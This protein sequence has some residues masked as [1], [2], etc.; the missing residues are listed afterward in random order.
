MNNRPLIG[1]TIGDP[2]GV[3]PEIVAR[4]LA[5]DALHRQAR[6]VVI[7]SDPVVTAAVKLVGAP[8]SVHPIQSPAQG[9]FSTGTLDLID[10]ANVDFETLLPGVA[11]PPAGRAAF[12]YVERAIEMA[13]SGTIDAFATAPINKEALKAGG[14]PYI[15][16]TEM[17]AK[18]TNSPHPMTMFALGNMRIFFLTRHVSLAEACR[19]ITAEL[20]VQGLQQADRELRRLGIA[21]PRI[22]VA[23]L[24]PHGGEGGL[25]GREEIEQITPAVMEARRQGV[26][27]TGPVPADAVFH[28]NRQG[29]FDAVLSL[30]HDQ[31]HIAAKTVDFERTVSVT[32]GLPFLRTSVD[33]GTAFDIAWKGIASAVGMEES[34]R[35]AAEYAPLFHR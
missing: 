10:L 1:V 8:L 20:V 3:G 21:R 16:H 23:A 12:Q 2:A 17:L 31:G 13:M 34:I 24:N 33:H 5:Q 26:E 27:V 4:A 25:F 19:Q 15:D 32:L 28:L 18:L 11:Q 14:V 9:S 30:Y 7:G 29:R 6:L 22:A 35:V